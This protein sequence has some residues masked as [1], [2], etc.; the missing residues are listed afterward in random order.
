M[1]VPLAA[2]MNPLTAALRSYV[3]AQDDPSSVRHQLRAASTVVVD[4]ITHA[5]LQQRHLEVRL[6]RRD[7]V[8]SLRQY[9]YR[10][11]GTPPADQHLQI[12]V[13]DVLHCEIMPN[14]ENHRP[15]G[16]FFPDDWIGSLHFIR[17]H[18]IDLNPHSISRNGSL[19]DTRLVEKYVMT[20]EEYNARDH[21]L[22]AWSRQQQVLDPAFTLQS[23]ATKHQALMAAR[24]R[25]KYGLSLPAGFYYDAV[26][27]QVVAMPETVEENKEGSAVA[28]V[29]TSDDIY[30]P[31]SVAHCRIGMRAEVQPGGRRGSVA[32]VGP[33]LQQH[34]VGVVLDEP[35]GRHD[36]IMGGQRYFTC[37]SN[38]GVF[39]RGPHVLV[40]DYP[41]RNE[42]QDSDDDEL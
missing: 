31:D 28:S 7:S 15:L 14:A 2:P 24:Q 38:H 17:L 33:C 29:A 12:H 32:Y 11:T 39:V 1:T 37:P 9:L 40:G 22:R 34:W 4:V 27:A 5:N 30:G 21:T 23:H 13:N 19:E 18:V 36:G 35:T 8:E 25:Y 20:D 16:F 10:T 6:D 3:T 26:A 42:W 41:V